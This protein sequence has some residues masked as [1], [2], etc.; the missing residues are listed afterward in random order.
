LQLL[1]TF[2]DDV[3]TAFLRGDLEEE[4]WMD[5][6][7]GIKLGENDE[8]L[9]LNRTIYGL[10]QSPREWISV[11]RKWLLTQGFTNR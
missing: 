6:P 3:P 10:K 2:H 11:I 9:F 1:E 5:Q 7:P 8:L 4:V